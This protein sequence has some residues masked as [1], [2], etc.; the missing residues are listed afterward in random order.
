MESLLSI[1]KMLLLERSVVG[2]LSKISGWLDAQD[3][4]ISELRR[5][6]FEFLE[7]RRWSHVL[8]EHRPHRFLFEGP[9]RPENSVRARR[10]QSDV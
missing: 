10:T 7:L 5:H 9:T 2:M 8:F 1:S 4:Q 3:A 6:H